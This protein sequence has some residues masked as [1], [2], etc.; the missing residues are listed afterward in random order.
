MLEFAINKINLSSQ[1]SETG[2]II[3]GYTKG[4]TMMKVTAQD[5]YSEALKG[6]CIYFLKSTTEEI[7]MK[8][9][10]KVLKCILYISFGLHQRKFSSNT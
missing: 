2:R 8:N 5:G 10:D 9:I 3:R 7:D 6:S 4:Q 1:Y